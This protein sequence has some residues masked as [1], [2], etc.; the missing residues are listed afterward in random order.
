MASEAGRR[1]GSG[2]GEMRGE[3]QEKIE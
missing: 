1:G 3:K 2:V